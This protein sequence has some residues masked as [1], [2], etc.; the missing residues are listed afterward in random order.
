MKIVRV[1]IDGTMNDI[2]V[3]LKK[4]RKPFLRFQRKS[5]QNRL[6]KKRRRHLPNQRKEKRR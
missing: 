1:K 3:N 2:D 6:R 4:K 5:Q